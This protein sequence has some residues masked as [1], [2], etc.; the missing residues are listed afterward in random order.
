MTRP[1]L[2]GSIIYCILSLSILYSVKIE[3]LTMTE[4]PRGFTETSLTN[5]FPPFAPT[6]FKTPSHPP[7]NWEEPRPYPRDRF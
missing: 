7:I 6:I 5:M 3:S 4:F 2:L 1:K